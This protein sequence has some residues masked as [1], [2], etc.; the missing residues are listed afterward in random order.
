[1]LM[2]LN[3][4]WCG[5]GDDSLD[6]GSVKLGRD[7][8][9]GVFEKQYPLLGSLDD[10]LMMSRSNILVAKKKNTHILNTWF[11][12]SQVHNKPVTYSVCHKLLCCNPGTVISIQC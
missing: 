6:V 1:M 9:R 10:T 3:R 11:P 12:F 2:D 8:H 5:G 7:L 4:Q